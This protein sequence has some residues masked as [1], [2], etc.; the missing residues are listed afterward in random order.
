[1]D[2]PSNPF[3]GDVLGVTYRKR[4]SHHDILVG[5]ARMTTRARSLVFHHTH[6]VKL[7]GKGAACPGNVLILAIFRVM[8]DPV[9]L[10]V[11]W[12]LLKLVFAARRLRL[13]A[14]STLITRA[15]SP[16]ARFV[17]MSCLVASIPA[18][19]D[20]MKVFVEPAKFDWTLVATVVKKKRQYCAA[21]GTKT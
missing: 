17:E 16:A 9:H 15:V 6:A 10:A 7:A 19:A 18:N 1:V 4:R 11:T 3:S 8:Q 13:N 12:V 5:A 2:K 20:A 14:A 21:T